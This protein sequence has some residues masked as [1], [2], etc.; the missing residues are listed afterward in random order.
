[1]LGK[2]HSFLVGSNNVN[3]FW[4]YVLLYWCFDNE[5]WY[6]VIQSCYYESEETRVFCWVIVYFVL[7]VS[8]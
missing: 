1:M 3:D 5:K 8:L 7:I 2:N 4:I 6:L